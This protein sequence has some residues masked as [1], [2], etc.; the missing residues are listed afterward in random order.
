M[1]RASVA[2]AVRAN[3]GDRRK[4]RRAT[5]TSCRKVSMVH[6]VHVDTAE[7][8]PY[9][10]GHA[11]FR[12]PTSLLRLPRVEDLFLPRTRDARLLPLGECVLVDLRSGLSPRQGI[13]RRHG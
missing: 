6:P 10:S 2:T 7:Y 9:V 8:P 1:P 13:A 5:R 11:G 4:A 3:P 12:D